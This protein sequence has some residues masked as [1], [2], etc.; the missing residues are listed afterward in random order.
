MPRYCT[1]CERMLEPKRHLGAG[2]V[3]IGLLT[4]GLGFLF[5]WAWPM[6][7][8]MCNGDVWGVAPKKS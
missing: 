7:C 5:W 1:L 8:P 2:Y 3:I 4:G 6:R